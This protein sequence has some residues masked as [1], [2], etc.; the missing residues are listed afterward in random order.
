[1]SA[2]L[3]LQ[4]TF[5]QGLILGQVSVLCL[6]LVVLRYLFL[7]TDPALPY[8]RSPL[9]DENESARHLKLPT[10][11]HDA[12]IVGGA[13]DP[14][15]AEWLNLILYQI[16]Q[17]YREDL[18]DHARGAAGDEAAREKIERWLNAA[19][20][21]SFMDP[22]RVHSVDLGSGCPHVS[23]VHF[24]HGDALNDIKIKLRL[25]YT[26]TV[27]VSLSTSVLFNYPAPYFARLPVSLSVSLSLFSSWATITPPSPTSP[28][29]T[30]SLSL[31]KSFTLDLKTVSLLGSRAKLADVPKLHEMI[32]SRIRNALSE[33]TISVALPPLTRSTPTPTPTA[34][35]PSSKD[36]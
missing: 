35:A 28:T 15:S 9:V 27:S 17:A 33:K 13:R 26:D 23:D 8:L 24:E 29:P 16:T 31:P 1:M 14:E 2:V 12:D 22:I 21:S 34:S 30:I 18:R 11:S 6:L 36:L 19:V 20:S 4:P 32:Q 25:S 5:T 10:A 7:D 3:S